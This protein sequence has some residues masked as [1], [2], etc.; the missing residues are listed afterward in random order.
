MKFCKKK[1]IKI[2]QIR[3]AFDLI[4]KLDTMHF[5]VRFTRPNKNSDGIEPL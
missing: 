4:I 3:F 2:I 5:V 1:I